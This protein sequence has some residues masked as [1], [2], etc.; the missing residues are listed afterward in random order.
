MSE[1]PGKLLFSTSV[2]E[3]KLLRAQEGKPIEITD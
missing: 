1:K 3:L 2:G